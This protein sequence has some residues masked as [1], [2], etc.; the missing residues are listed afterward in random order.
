MT[1]AE[2]LDRAAELIEERGHAVGT[3]ENDDGALCARGAVR[4]AVYG[5]SGDPGGDV[6]QDNVYYTAQLHLTRLVPGW[7]VLLWSDSSTKDEV[8]ATLRRAAVAAQGGQQQ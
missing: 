7:S 2:A 6:T 1:P 4:V 5:H 8:V 3:Y